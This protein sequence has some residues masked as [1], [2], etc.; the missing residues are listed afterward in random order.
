MNYIDIGRFQLITHLSLY[1]NKDIYQGTDLKQIAHMYS[2]HS[3]DN[4]RIVHS[5]AIET[6]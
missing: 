5:F 6:R 1:H 3:I 4:N 2:N